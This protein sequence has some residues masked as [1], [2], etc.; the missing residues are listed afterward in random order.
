MNELQNAATVAFTAFRCRA[1]HAMARLEI[2]ICALT[3]ACFAKIETDM[4]MILETVVAAHYKTRSLQKM[5]EGPKVV[6]DS[7]MIVND[8]L[9][10]GEVMQILSQA[11][12]D[13]TEPMHEYVEEQHDVAK[14]KEGED[15]KSFELLSFVT[16]SVDDFFIGRVQGLVVNENN[17]SMKEDMVESFT[18]AN[19]ESEVISVKVEVVV[20]SEFKQDTHVKESASEF[21]AFFPSKTTLGPEIELADVNDVSHKNDSAVFLDD[22]VIEFKKLVAKSDVIGQ[23]YL[24]EAD[25]NYPSLIAE[26][27]DK[28]IVKV[29]VGKAKSL[30]LSKN[31]TVFEWDSGNVK[32]VP[33]V[34]SGLVGCMVV[35]IVCG[36]AAYAALTNDGF[37]YSWGYSF[38]KQCNLEPTRVEE[39]ERIV[40]LKAGNMHFCGL[41]DCGIAFTW[42]SNAFYQLGRNPNLEQSHVPA[43]MNLYSLKVASVFCGAFQTT[44][45]D[46]AG[47]MYAVGCSSHGQL[48]I[49]NEFSDAAQ[50][51]FLFKV[52]V[53]D[54]PVVSMVGSESYSVL[55]HANGKV[56]TVGDNCHGQLGVAKILSADR[57]HRAH[58]PKAVMHISAK[59]PMTVVVEK[60]KYGGVLWAWGKFSMG[61]KPRKYDMPQMDVLAAEC[62][63]GSILLLLKLVA[64]RLSI[65][66]KIAKA[67][68]KITGAA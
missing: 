11:F 25:G 62:G 27:D 24:F 59:G 15:N 47:N 56:S 64:P 58:G 36:D 14:L 2:E 34:V 41:S 21:V 48:G 17:N 13:V 50:P 52:R 12:M 44:I 46:A 51:R 5:I 8:I 6:E 32:S 37:V 65:G 43:A 66:A 60:G 31:G 53:D 20:E 3:G 10:E 63:E 38:E 26:L 28:E 49:G 18:D 7:V 33:T 29:A 9:K 45:I 68:K 42:G 23:V 39:L 35:D 22:E 1:L 55:L 19:S 54:A 4:R 57:P 40:S 16:A 61:R 67:W 30:A